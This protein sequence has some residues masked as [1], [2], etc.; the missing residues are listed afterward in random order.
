MIDG[1]MM[2]EIVPN[3]YGATSMVPQHPPAGGYP[4]LYP[5]QPDDPVTD[6][7][8]TTVAFAGTDTDAGGMPEP[9]QLDW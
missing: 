1:A 7:K 3:V 4:A 8:T 2:P 9:P 5:Q 6:V